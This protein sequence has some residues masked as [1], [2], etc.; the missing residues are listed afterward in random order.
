MNDIEV[1]VSEV[2]SNAMALDSLL[3]NFDTTLD[4]GVPDIVPPKRSEL[5]AV[6]RKLTNVHVYNTKDYLK[7][8]LV[9]QEWT[10]AI[11]KRNQKAK[12]RE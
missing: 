1:P 2:H 8:G 7:S 4:D 12:L 11:K 10:Q 6:D 3:K 9:E 5:F